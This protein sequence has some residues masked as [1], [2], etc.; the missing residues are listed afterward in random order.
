MPLLDVIDEKRDPRV[1]FSF[2]FFAS[3]ANA[4]DAVAVPCRRWAIRKDVSEVAVAHAA[5]HL[6]SH[7]SM[8]PIESFNDGR[9][10]DGTIKRRPA[11][12]RIE[13]VVREEQR[14]VAPF[15]M[16]HPAF[17]PLDKGRSERSFCSVLAHD[18]VRIGTELVEPIAFVHDGRIE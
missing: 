15:A 13:L 1:P 8:G 7:H 14:R 16:V 2:L 12:S 6:R 3:Q 4:V 11:A 5:P 10:R 17:F 18:P 9:T